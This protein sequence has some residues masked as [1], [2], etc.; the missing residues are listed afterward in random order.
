MRQYMPTGAPPSGAKVAWARPGFDQASYDASRAGRNAHAMHELYRRFP[1]DELNPEV[2]AHWA[3]YGVRKEMFE[4]GTEHRYAVYTPT[5]MDPT[6]RYALVYVSH[7]GREPINKTET[8]GFP[9]LVGSQKFICVLPNN[10]GESNEGVEEEFPR[11][12]GEL[13]RAGYPIDH[14]RIYAAGYSAG[15]DATGVLACVYPGVLAAVSPSPG[16]NLYAKG[17]WY[18]DPTSYARN[19]PYQLPLI[20]VAGTMDGGDRYPLEESEHLANFGIWMEHIAKVADF[21]APS[22]AESQELVTSSPDAAKRA[23]G[24]DFHRTF[25]TEL[26]EVEWLVGDFLGPAG[27]VAARFVTGVG[28]PH[29]Q[30]G[31]HVP[32]IWDFIKHYSRD[33]TTGESIYSP[34]VI[35]GIRSAAAASQQPAEQVAG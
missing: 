32:L 5:D 12:L 29:A 35:D 16:G 11:I 15:S 24:F 31:Y 25:S 26:E 21:T 4:A 28:L 14:G 23:F 2:F 17:R 6:Q 9:A 3:S 10:L 22:L 1:D 13:V 34:V 7:G 30:T 20:S 19:A 33:L 27:H 18:A 8:S